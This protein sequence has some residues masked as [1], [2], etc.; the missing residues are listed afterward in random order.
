[1]KFLNDLFEFNEYEIFLAAALIIGVVIAVRISKI[2]IQKDNN[3]SARENKVNSD[4]FIAVFGFSIG[5]A[6]TIV[7]LVVYLLIS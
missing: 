4:L 6:L 3:A 1:M 5:I 2:I 7:G